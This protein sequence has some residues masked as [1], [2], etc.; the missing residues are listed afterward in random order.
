[1]LKTTVFLVDNHALIRQG[2]RRILEQHDNV[3]VVGEATAGEEALE[4][5]A[6]LKPTIVVVDLNLPGMGGLEVIR[7][8][9]SEFPKVHGIVLSSHTH[10]AHVYQAFKAGASAY[11]VTQGRERELEAAIEAVK[12]GGAYL[13]PLVSRP[14]I[15][16]YMKYAPRETGYNN[17]PLTNKEHEVLLLLTQGFTSKQIAQRLQLSPHTIDVHRKNI[18]KKLE[19]HSVPELIKWAIRTKMISVEE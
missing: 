16:V 19:L 13:S 4:R 1:M 3:S 5:V 9:R 11:V 10:D 17:S 14:V 2:C 12:S 7:R 15:D 6:V 18:M 8:L